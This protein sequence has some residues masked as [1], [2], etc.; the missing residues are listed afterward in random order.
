MVLFLDFDGVLHPEPCRNDELFCRRAL[1]EEVMREFVDVEIVV[2]STWRNT[3]SMSELRALFS[4]DVGS[5]IVGRTPQWGDLTE[6][7]EV[8]GQY[9]RHI[10]AEGWMRQ[11][12]RAWEPWLALDDRPY[13]FK[14][15]LP[16]LLHCDP[17]KGLDEVVAS[18]LRHRLA[19]RL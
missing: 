16:N 10:E 13:L 7:L 2:S 1:F 11:E 6:L 9:P 3:R 12:G 18:T 19:R 4:G 5:R 17:R 15:F 8:I 14:P